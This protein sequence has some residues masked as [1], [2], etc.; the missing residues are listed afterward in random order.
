[1][2]VTDEELI[3]R[4]IRGDATAFETLVN[5]YQKSALRFAQRCIGQQTDAEDLTQEAFLQVH[6]HA[7]QY[8]PDAASFKTWFFA[9]LTNLCRKTL[10]RNKSLP[11][12]E[13]PEDAPAID[14]LDS[15]LAYEEERAALAAAVA[16]LPP[17]QRLA[18]IL[19]YEEGFSYAEIAAA[20]GVSIKAVGSL[21]VRAKR[22]LRRELVEFE[23]K[24][25]D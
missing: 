23:K 24:S 6:R 14:D 11:L 20:L 16:K 13:L 5:R 19:R 15:D 25:S 22:T 12:I 7:H 1:M 4:V 2:A 9:I 18:L 8:D 3:M 21:L 10:R 17:N